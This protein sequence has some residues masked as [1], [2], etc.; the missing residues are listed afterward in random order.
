MGPVPVS[1]PVLNHEGGGRGRTWDGGAPSNRA[2]HLVANFDS[3]IGKTGTP[4]GQEWKRDGLD[5][6]I[7]A[8]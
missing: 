6:K 5:R 8:V 7:L 4:W 2:T 1:S 3:K